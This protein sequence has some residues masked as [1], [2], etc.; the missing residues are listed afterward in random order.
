MFAAERNAFLVF[1]AVVGLLLIADL[2]LLHR[3]PRRMAVREALAWTGFWVL[4]AL[5]FGAALP[6]LYEQGIGGLRVGE[7]V[8][9]GGQAALQFFTG[10][11]IELSLS[12]DN[13]FVF[14]AIFGYFAVPDR[15]QH[16]VLFWGILAAVVL[17]GAMIFAGV[18]LIE[19][20]HWLIYLLGVFL[21]ITGLRLLKGGGA[22]VD[23]SKNL[24]LKWARKILPISPDDH[25]ERFVVR[26]QGRF[27]ATRLLLVLLC[28]E[29]TDV[30][31]ALDSIPAALAISRD[32]FVV[33][34][35]NLLAILGLRSLYFA[36]AGLIDAFEYLNY[37]L[38]A[39]LTFVGLKMLGAAWFTIPTALSLAVVGSLLAI[40]VIA[41]LVHPGR[42]SGRG[43]GD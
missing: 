2:V 25:G 12:V 13:L 6:W 39:V 7:H 8:S 27:M 11:V 18:A 28:V 17:R 5:G 16:R 26:V 32:P 29:M 20:F 14:L 15:H 19:R 33:Y 10:Y 4:L 42:R 41:S 37:G 3:R 23:P 31:F 40:S 9:S 1:N 21:V 22:E 34:S 43:S 30:V 38:A 35:S 36:V 24:V